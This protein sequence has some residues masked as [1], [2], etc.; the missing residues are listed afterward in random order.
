MSVMHPE[1]EWFLGRYRDLY[2]A[3]FDATE[4]AAFAGRTAFRFLGFDDPGN[5]NAQRLAARYATYAPERKPA[6]LAA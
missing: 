6:W 5:C 1:L 4:A 3:Q 2:E